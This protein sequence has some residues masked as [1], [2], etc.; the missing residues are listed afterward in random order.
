[1]CMCIGVHTHTHTHT[2]TSPL[3]GFV[4]G[5]HI[6]RIL[7]KRRKMVSDGFGG[8]AAVH[9]GSI[10]GLPWLRLLSKDGIVRL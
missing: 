9:V 2:H 5:L 8:D 7:K 10:A 1:M 6:R 3:T 4:I